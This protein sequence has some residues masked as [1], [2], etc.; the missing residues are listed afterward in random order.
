MPCYWNLWCILFIFLTIKNRSVTPVSGAESSE[1]EDAAIEQDNFSLF[2]SA[3]SRRGFLNNSGTAVTAM[4]QW[5]DDAI[6]S[7]GWLG[8]VPFWLRAR[9][10]F[11]L[12]F[13][14]DGSAGPT[15]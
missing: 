13:R 15:S 11:L 12:L 5:T 2:L 9:I 10:A 1:D 3:L 8:V 7:V 14:P 4:G 6:K